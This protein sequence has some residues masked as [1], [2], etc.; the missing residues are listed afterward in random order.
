MIGK[1]IVTPIGTISTGSCIK[2]GQTVNVNSRV[3]LRNGKIIEVE[4]ITKELDYWTFRFKEPLSVYRADKY[5]LYRFS[6]ASK[7]ALVY[8][9]LSDYT[10]D[11]FDIIEIVGGNTYSPTNAEEEL[12]LL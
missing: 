1:S 12:L 9:L 8:S 3:R 7:D 6:R 5:Y 4:D 2:D 11:G 10:D